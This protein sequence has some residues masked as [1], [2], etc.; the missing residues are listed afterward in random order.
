MRMTGRIGKTF[1]AFAI[2]LALF[3]AFGYA[4]GA[5]SVFAYSELRCPPGLT[6]QPVSI[7]PVFVC[8]SQ[9]PDPTTIQWPAVVTTEDRVAL[10]LA[11][12]RVRVFDLDYVWGRHVWV[13]FDVPPPP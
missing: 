2:S 7:A 13:A 6:A 3:V 1:R 12:I 5:R 4:A 9:F 8:R 11:N 10:Y